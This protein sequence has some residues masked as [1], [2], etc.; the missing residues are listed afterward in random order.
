M[1]DMWD[2][3]EYEDESEGGDKHFSFGEYQGKKLICLKTDYDIKNK[4]YGFSFGQAKAKLIVR[5]FD[6]IKQFA[7]EE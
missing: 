5:Y 3:V 1:G 4:K 2:E 6:K 7:N